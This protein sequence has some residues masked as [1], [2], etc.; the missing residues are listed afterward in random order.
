MLEP[1]KISNA[2]GINGI[3]VVIIGI[4]PLREAFA[5]NPGVTEPE[6]SSDIVY[7]APATIADHR[8][9]SF[10]MR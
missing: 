1:D 3:D 7:G 10:K 9:A 5:A 2:C 4:G 6:R 8:W